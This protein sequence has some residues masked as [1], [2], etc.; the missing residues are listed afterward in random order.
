MF[1]ESDPSIIQ[2]PMVVSGVE[3][4][5]GL[6]PSLAR[7]AGRMAS[8]GLL[9]V[10]SAIAA[11]SVEAVVGPEFAYADTLGYPSSGMP[12]EHYPYNVPG[13]CSHY[14]WGP[15]HTEAYNDPSEY[16][17]RGYAYRNCTDYV[18]WKESTIGVT[19][20]PT[21]GDGG[22]WYANAPASER[23]SMPAVGDAA[24]VPGNPGHVAYVEAV[25]SNGT[26]TVSEYNHDA[27][28]D[29]DT[30]T[31]TPSS[32]G[33]SGYVNFGVHPSSANTSGGLGVGNATYEGT[34]EFTYNTTLPSNS[35]LM[36]DNIEFV[37]IMQSDGNLVE[38]GPGYNAVWNTGT[39]GHPGAYFAY[40]PDGNLVVYDASGH[41]I[42]NAGVSGT[43]GR[44]ILQGDGNIVEYNTSNQAIWS[45]G[46]HS[47]VS[48]GRNF[49]S[50][51]MNPG[52]TMYSGSYVQSADG[53]HQLVLQGDGNLVLYG[54]AYHV[55]WNIGTQ[56][57]SGTYLNLQYGGNL[58]LYEP[59]NIPLW[60]DNV[61]ATAGN[62]TLQNDGN[63]VEYDSNGLAVWSSGTSGKY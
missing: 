16:S 4:S 19:V 45:T 26:I 29:G 42:W 1:Q 61:S 47:Y 50:N 35:F 52:D 40:Q 58:I 6:L 31:G 18:A 23:S 17:S 25:N 56:G 37:L 39:Y 54:P 63:F 62:A 14:D 8:A 27:M 7:R 34:S 5:V 15:I 20:P 53:L 30:W 49:G 12:C 55:L 51:H 57:H 11:G 38:Y 41:P 48:S 44:F 13:S 22:Q 10:S 32:R 9:V 36:S 59:G 2:A 33:F 3:G 43:P 24:V 21:L 60:T 46:T 28:G